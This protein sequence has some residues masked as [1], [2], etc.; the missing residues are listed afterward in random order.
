MSHNLNNFVTIC[1]KTYQH[2]QRN[3]AR[4]LANNTRGSKGLAK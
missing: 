4:I 2:C 3:T 1:N